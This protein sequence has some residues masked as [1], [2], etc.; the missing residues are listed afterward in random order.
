MTPMPSLA[1]FLLSCVEPPPDVIPAGFK[2]LRL[3]VAFE[4]GPGVPLLRRAHRPA[5]GETLADV[6]KARLGSRERVDE[7]VALNPGVDPDELRAGDMIWLPALD[8][9]PAEAAERSEESSPVESV[10]AYANVGWSR[11]GPSPF[12]LGVDVVSA[13]ITRQRKLTLY[14]VP[15]E[16]FSDFE[17]AR[18]ARRQTDQPSAIEALRD[19]G[20]IRILEAPIDTSYVPEDDAAERRVDRYRIERSLETGEFSLTRIASRRFDE[21]GEPVVE[22]G[23]KNGAFALLLLSSAGCSGLWLSRRRRREPSCALRGCP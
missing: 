11:Q 5:R 7:L 8:A 17:A 23:R 1:L 22:D 6:A 20:R 10:R 2:T 18:K 16:A 3:E 15:D 21:R 13:A 12:P 19:A 4:R 14:L 9:E